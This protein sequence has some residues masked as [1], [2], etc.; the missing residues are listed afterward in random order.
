MIR[1]S[2]IL[3]FL[4]TLCSHGVAQDL[5][6]FVELKSKGTIPDDFTTLSSDKFNQD[7]DRNTNKD[8]DK[9]FFLSTRFFIDELLLS[10]RV[11]FNDPVTDYLNK[12]A[13]QV[14]RREKIT[15]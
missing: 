7:Y 4:I 13:K 5:S 14:L 10:G 6:K 8:L 11:L 3:A 1:K 15:A 12:V 9:D 2:Y